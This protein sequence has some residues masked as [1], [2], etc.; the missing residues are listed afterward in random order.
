MQ[1]LIALG[2]AA[3]P[4]ALDHDAAQGYWVLKQDPLALGPATRSKRIIIIIII[5][6]LI[7]IIIFLISITLIII[8]ITI[9]IIQIRIS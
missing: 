1:D 6:F 5:I 9:L 4:R 7:Q 3:D 8:K 2:L